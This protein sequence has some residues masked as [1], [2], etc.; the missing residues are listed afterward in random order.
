MRVMPEDAGLWFLKGKM[1]LARR[2]AAA[3]AAFHRAVANGLE[4]SRVLAFLGQIAFE[5]RDFAEVK[6]IFSALSE[7]QY[8]SRLKPAV[9]YWTG[10]QGNAAA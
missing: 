10:E 7:G 4:E 8:A 2:D 9:K 3:E 1:L 5:R 6:R